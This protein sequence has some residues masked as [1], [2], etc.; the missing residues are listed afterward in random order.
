[1]RLT[2]IQHFFL[3]AAS[4]VALP[5]PSPSGAPTTK[6]SILDGL[7]NP[8]LAKRDITL[9]YILY[10]IVLDGSNTNNWEPFNVVGELMIT[11]GITETGVT[12]GINQAD[13]IVSVGEPAANPIAGSVWYT[14]N[15]YL[16]KAWSGTNPEL[17]IDYAYVTVTGNSLNVTVD[18]KLAGA[19][20]LS[21]FNAHSGLLANVYIIAGGTWDIFVDDEGNLTG[22]VVLVGNGYIEPSVA[23]Y[24]AAIAG[25]QKDSGSITF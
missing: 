11:T 21:S 17:A 12:N 20:Q 25:V 10:D 22:A 4:A 1:M 18:T 14:S 2:S 5:G 16:Y 9:D 15:R 13:I 24:V 6:S 3:F 7:K 19:N 8:K 23:P